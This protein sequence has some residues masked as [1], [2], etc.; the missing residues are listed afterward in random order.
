[1]ADRAKQPLDVAYA[2]LAWHAARVAERALL[3]QRNACV[4]DK[5]AQRHKDV[6]ESITGDLP[7]PD[8]VHP[9]WKHIFREVP[10]DGDQVEDLSD[11]CHGCLER[12]RLH[13]LYRAA[14][15]EGGRLQS[16]LSHTCRGWAKKLQE[17]G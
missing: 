13:K 6:I 10:P 17:A 16:A 15:Q 1:M 7:V 4:C 5:E 8:R 9:C 14:H 3:K 11:C 12:V 2:A